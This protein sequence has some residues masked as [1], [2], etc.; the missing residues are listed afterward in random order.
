M[1]HIVICF[2]FT[3]L[4]I[5]KQKEA[6]QQF[7]DKNTR[8]KVNRTYEHIISSSKLIRIWKV[9]SKKCSPFFFSFPWRNFIAD[10]HEKLPNCTTCWKIDYFEVWFGYWA[11]CRFVS[12]HFFFRPIL[13]WV[14][15]SKSLCNEAQ[16]ERKEQTEI[17]EKSRVKGRKRATRNL[18][19]LEARRWMQTNPK[20]VSFDSPI[21]CCRNYM[22]LW[23]NCE[24][25]LSRGRLDGR[26]L[27]RLHNCDHL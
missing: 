20:N 22:E 19:R 13:T 2:F 8:T 4:A 1:I 10:L 17:M 14:T 16:R 3:I 12:A 23:A 18:K 11:Q 27:M 15:H 24:T 7:D 26:A 6:Q 21:T 25:E 9:W 5:A